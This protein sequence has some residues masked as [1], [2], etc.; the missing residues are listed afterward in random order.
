MRD[1]HVACLV[2]A[3]VA[4][5]L[6]G[7]DVS[8]VPPTPEAYEQA[9]ADCAPHGGL[10]SV[11]TIVRLKPHRIEARCTDGLRVTRLIGGG[12]A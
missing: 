4:A 9:K 8:A 7:C 11:E 12:N 10:S 6:A 5:A 2:I 1:A 3:L